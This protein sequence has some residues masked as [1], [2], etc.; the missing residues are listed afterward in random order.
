MKHIVKC[1]F[2]K[3]LRV[4]KRMNKN[5]SPGPD[6]IPPSF[7]S[8]C[9]YYFANPLCRIYNSS[10]TMGSVPYEWKFDD[11]T[12]VYKR[13]GSK[14]DISNYRPISVTSIFSKILEAIIKDRIID[15]LF[16][17]N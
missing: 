2:N 13:K 4:V 7:I 10:L 5:G 6:G 14:N 9:I 12:P 3:I 17:N 1:S 16:E 15:F 8:K 11:I